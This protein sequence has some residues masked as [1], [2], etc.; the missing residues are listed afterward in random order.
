MRRGFTLIELLVVIAIIAILAAI[1][2]PVFAKARAKAQQNNCLS[3]VKQLMLGINM[4][5]SDN[6]QQYW[7]YNWAQSGVAGAGW[8][9]VVY[10]Y[11]KNSQIYLCPTSDCSTYT[12]ANCPPLSGSSCYVTNG[13]TPPLGYNLEKMLYPAEMWV[14]ADKAANCENQGPMGYGPNCAGNS[15]VGHPHNNG[16]NVGFLDGHAKWMGMMDPMWSGCAW[17]AVADPMYL[18]VRHFYYGTD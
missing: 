15:R 2:F 9:S 13:D 1:L 6:D 3:N 5:L 17:P 11:V 18:P 16:A 12:L 7:A 4:Y 14:I 10:P 8:A